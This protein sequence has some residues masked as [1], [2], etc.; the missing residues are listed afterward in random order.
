MPD[1]PSNFWKELKRRK[2]IRVML[3]YV[4][5]SAGL[6]GLINDVYEHLGLPEWAPTLVIVILAIGFP[7][8]IIFA[9]IFDI[10]SK[11]IRKTEPLDSAIE[12]KEILH[13][14]AK[15]EAPEKSIIVLPFENIS[16]DPEQEYF[17]DGL[18]EEIITDLSH[19]HD[20][21]VISRNSAMTLKGTRDKITSIAGD[22]N[23]RYVLEGSVRKSGN[24]IRITAQLIDAISDTHLWAEK[25]DGTLDDVFEIQEKVSRSIAGALE[26]KISPSENQK[27]SEHPIENIQAYEVY[28]KA[29]YEIWQANEKSLD[30]ALKLLENALE[31]I[32]EK[33]L[34]YAGMG[35]VYFQYVNM[36]IKQESYIQK[37]EESIKKTFE[38]D[39]DSPQ[40]HL[41]LGLVSSE[42]KGDRKKGIYHLEI[43]YAD[44]PNDPENL[45]WLSFAYM[46]VG[47]VSRMAQLVERFVMVDPL[48]NMSHFMLSY[49]YVIRGQFDIGLEQ[50]I[51]AKSIG[52]KNIIIIFHHA[53]FLAYSKRFD[54]ALVPIDECVEV[55]PEHMF[56]QLALLLK[57]AIQ[58]DHKKVSEIAKEEAHTATARRDAQY[59]Y[60]IASI[61]SI[62]NMKNEA[63]EWFEN[64]INLGF[65]NYPFFSE[66]DTLL[67]NIRGE[68]K[69][70]KLMIKVKHEWENFEVNES[71]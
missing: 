24:K 1:N 43:A 15:K 48:N 46:I 64:S 8:A 19:I 32:G 29:R 18:T 11:G 31:I 25:Y 57:Y 71:K 27:I 30:R 45:L 35:Y 7:I 34:I 50:V 21:S 53:L 2:V 41:L 65:I 3:V 6:V 60:W 69:F 37:L 9:W 58:K 42:F 44:N 56:T 14:A 47:K 28:L 39:A 51:K 13:I 20:L 63:L 49:L 36:G 12:G 16:S 23:V 10:T 4:T 59:S 54:E 33:A 62:A 52:P 22:F 26:M 40:G 66:H 70:N 17:S 55:E 61:Y 67:D 38:L 68:E 5:V